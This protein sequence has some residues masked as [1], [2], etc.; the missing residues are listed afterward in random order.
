LLA[1]VNGTRLYVERHGAG[2]PMVVLHGGPGFDQE[3]L[4]PGLL[5]LADDVELV[6]VDLRGCGRSDAAPAEE[7]TLEQLADDVAALGIEDPIVF[8]HSAGGFV[9]L[10]YAV[11]HPLAGLIACQT[12]PALGING[13]HPP[14]GPSKRGGREIGALA[15]RLFAGDYSPEIVEAVAPYYAGPD[16]M[17]VPL[18]LVQRSRMNGAFA[19]HFFGVLGQDYDVRP[20]LHAITAPTLVIAGAHDWVTA[21]AASEAIAADIPGARLVE[22]PDAGHFG[23]SET[24]EPFLAAVRDWLSRA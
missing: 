4:K 17:D 13:E 9:A 20:Q 5:P 10:T 23:F 24:P 14:P 3:Y 7:C 2:R 1:E 12:A 22:L 11:R 18:P 16:H 8:G 19:A 15:R 6:F 21:P